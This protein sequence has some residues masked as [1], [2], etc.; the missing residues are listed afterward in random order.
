MTKAT[1][2]VTES[3]N[4][5]FADLDAMSTLERLKLMNAEDHGVAIAVEKVLPQI[6]LA[7]EKIV[8]SFQSGGRLIYVGAGTSGRLGVLDASECPPTFGTGPDQVTAIMAGGMDAVFKAVEGAEDN[9][10]EG[11]VAMVKVGVGCTDTVVGISASGSAP[12]VLGALTEAKSLGAS[13]VAVANNSHCR[14]ESIADITIAPVV[15]PEV[16]AGSTRMK[17]GTAQKMVLNL[18]STN[19]MIETGKTFG[20]RM[21]DLKASNAKLKARAINMTINITGAEL[22]AVESALADSSGH[23]KLA[24]LMIERGLNAAAAT[25][26]LAKNG[27]FLRKAL[28]DQVLLTDPPG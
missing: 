3:V 10:E 11:K 2:L 4:P 28:Q 19:A 13:T 14:A 18:L 24:V 5:V 20:N 27:G 16:I 1:D 9:F 6:A 21:V 7:I 26:L 8:I 12:Y 17:A 22:V 25:K 23:V 15:G